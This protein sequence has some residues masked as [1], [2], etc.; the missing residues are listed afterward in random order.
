MKP[1][2]RFMPLA[3]ALVLAVPVF[4]GCETTGG[5]SDPTSIYYGTGFHDPWYYGG[6]YDRGDIVVTPPSGA[7]P[8]H[9]IARPPVAGPRPMPMPAPRPMPR[10]R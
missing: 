10:A 6:Y 4:S 9:P 8:S 5:S 2:P 7:H 3:A 1:F